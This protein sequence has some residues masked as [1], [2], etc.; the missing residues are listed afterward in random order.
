MLNRSNARRSL[1]AFAFERMDTDGINQE[2]RDRFDGYLWENQRFMH[3]PESFCASITI[4]GDQTP[5]YMNPADC[6]F[7]IVSGYQPRFDDDEG[8]V[9]WLP[10][11]GATHFRVL[12]LGEEAARCELIA[13]FCDIYVP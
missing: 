2:K 12:W 9:F 13:G 4:Y 5:P 7:G 1:S 3:L 6:F 11:E 8:R 10:E